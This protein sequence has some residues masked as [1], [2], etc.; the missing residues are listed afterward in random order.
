MLD[1]VQNG[2]EWLERREKPGLGLL[3]GQLSSEVEEHSIVP[4]SEVWEA[5]VLPPNYAC[6]LAQTLL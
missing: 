3:G 1:G 6:S 2:P 5:C 4:T